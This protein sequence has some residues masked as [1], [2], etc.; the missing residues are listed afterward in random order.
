MELSVVKWIEPNCAFEII[1]IYLFYPFFFFILHFNLYL[2]II[3][4]FLP[5]AFSGTQVRTVRTDSYAPV[6]AVI[7]QWFGYNLWLIILEDLEYN[8]LKHKKGCKW[9]DTKKNEC[10][11]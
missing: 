8:C 1:K 5:S 6:S 3:I 9:Q 7:S 2:I 4:I 10:A 11:F